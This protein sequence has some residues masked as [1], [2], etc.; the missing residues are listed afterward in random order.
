MCGKITF[1]N[2]YILL[3]L[4]DLSKAQDIE[5]GDGTTTVVVIT[6]SMLDAASKLM[7]KGN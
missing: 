2:L 7:D 5:A 4:V 3:Q 1:C 6:G